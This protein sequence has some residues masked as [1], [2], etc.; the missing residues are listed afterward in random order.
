MNMYF[1]SPAV[2]P[3]LAWLLLHSNIFSTQNTPYCT[4]ILRNC[5]FVRVDI[6]VHLRKLINL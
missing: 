5:P 2:P 6:S 1:T 4:H 3:I